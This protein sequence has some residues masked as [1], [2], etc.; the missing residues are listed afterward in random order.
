MVVN[1][2]GWKSG[3]SWDLSPTGESDT[4]TYKHITICDQCLWAIPEPWAAGMLHGDQV[5]V[6]QAESNEE[7]QAEMSDAVLRPVS[8]LSVYLLTTS[9]ILTKQLS[10]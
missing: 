2:S 3:C 5:D 1:S 7:K 10:L 4:L 8:S 9:D 6:M